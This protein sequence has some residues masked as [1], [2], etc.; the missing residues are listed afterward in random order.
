MT[1]LLLVFLIIVVIFLAL[2][3]RIKL[4][5]KILFITLTY[6]FLI[7]SGLLPYL[8]LTPLQAPFVDLPAPQWKKHNVIILLGGGTDQL[9]GLNTYTPSVMIYSRLYKTAELYFSCVKQHSCKIIISGGPIEHTEKSNALVYEQ[10]LMK[11]GV[12]LDDFILEFNSTDTQTNAEF[13]KAI[14]KQSSFDQIVLV[15][16][17]IHMQRSLLWFS[18]FDVHAIPAS[19]DY[20][21]PQLTMTSL[22][23]NFALTDFAL[24]EYLGIVEFY[25]KASFKSPVM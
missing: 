2:N 9:P 12:P 21:A 6:I 23:Y 1:L 25:L 4:C 16:S 17:G 7:G 11:L 22:G 19:S 18:H 13:T 14:L 24:H 20:L 8:L 3:N 5:C 10:T 15:T